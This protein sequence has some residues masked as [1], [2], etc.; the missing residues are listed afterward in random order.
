MAAKKS[1]SLLDIQSKKKQRSIFH[2]CAFP[3][4]CI[5]SET[6]F[7]IL[8]FHLVPELATQRDSQQNC[9]CQEKRE[10][11]KV[12]G[13]VAQGAEFGERDAAHAA[14]RP[15][16]LTPQ[17]AQ[18]RGTSILNTM[19]ND[20]GATPNEIMLAACRN[21]QDDVLE[22][23]LM[24]KG[25][26]LDVN[27]TDSI[28]DTALH[29]AAKYGALN[30]MEILVN[31]DDINVNI[32]NKMQK[33]TPLH[34][35]VQY[36]DDPDL[37]LSMV[38]L[39]LEAGADPKIENRDRATPLMLVDPKDDDMKDLLERATAGYQ[40]DDSDIADEAEYADDDGESV[41]SE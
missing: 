40:V 39:L 15:A 7:I 18:L 37:A 30:C 36:R 22:D 16:D 1:N 5:A 38:D 25:D 4:D 23:L 26:Q 20:E 24:T 2:H 14:A 12:F 31:L 11:A 32:Q 27:F 34:K 29:Y 33:E 28:G 17:A 8:I 19:E 6:V 3:L 21:D 41:A 10:T 35:A 9:S 13:E